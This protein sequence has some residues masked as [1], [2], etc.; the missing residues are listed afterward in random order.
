MWKRLNLRQRIY[1]TLSGLVGITFLGGLVMV[2]YTY[3]VEKVMVDII[4]KNVVGLQT[5][6]ALETAI[7]NQK[8]FVSYYYLDGDPDWLKQL[9]DYRRIFSE[10]LKEA[11]QSA[12]NQQQTEAIEQIQIQYEQYITLKDQVIA[13]YKAGERNAVTA[14]HRRVRSQ[15]FTILDLCEKYKNMHIQSVLAAQNLTSA[16]ATQLR[17][18][19]A[20]AI[21]VNIILA[22]FLAFILIKQVLNPIARLLQTTSPGGRVENPDNVVIALGRSVEGLIQNVD[23]TQSELAKSREHLLQVEKMAMVG[24][25][26]AGMAH[27]IRNPFT[28]V[29]MRLFSLGRTLTLNAAQ[30]E[31]FDVISG[32]IRHIDTIVQNFLEFSRPP[33]LVMQSVNPS[34]VV[35][36]TLKLLTQRLKS[37]NVNVQIVRAR[38]LPDVSADPEQLKEVFVNLFINACEA[39]GNGGTITVHE[40]VHHEK[41]LQK[42]A[43]IRISDD[44]P[45][46]PGTII[47]RVLEPFFTTKEEGT[48]LGLSIASRIIEEHG[49]RIEV[50]S[51]E[52]QGTTF[53]ITLPAIGDTP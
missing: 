26:A 42:V 2:W 49:G 9:D 36:N 20:V 30:K 8:G 5:A 28:S 40:D 16:R 1:A 19:A 52:Y 24:K 32:E 27:S 10:R 31:D 14:L 39:M 4:D 3:R 22:F 33:K 21:A 34:S 47:D 41:A 50:S 25:L 29:K 48:G 37:Y 45:G 12:Q 11:R 15:F 13:Q 23:Q 43:R 53:T 18:I 38:K 46:I 17:T 44:G 35:D 7:V 51:V 6:E